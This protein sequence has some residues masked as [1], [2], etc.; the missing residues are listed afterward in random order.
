MHT[1]MD[2]LPHPLHSVIML[3]LLL[4]ASSMHRQR[5]L[6]HG[7]AFKNLTVYGSQQSLPLSLA[8]PN[9]QA[10]NHAQTDS[11]STQSAEMCLL[12]SDVSSCPLRASIAS[13]AAIHPDILCTKSCL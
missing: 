4:P 1:Q 5:S 8:V 7:Q 12:T 10:S 2:S 3:L 11:Q 6:I 13:F 9:I